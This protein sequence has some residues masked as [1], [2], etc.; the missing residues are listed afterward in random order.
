MKIGN[1]YWVRFKVGAVRDWQ[2]GHLRNWNGMLWFALVYDKA[3]CPAS[4]FEVGE[5]IVKP[6]G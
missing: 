3:H 4:I 6:C 2:V 1:Y 5:E